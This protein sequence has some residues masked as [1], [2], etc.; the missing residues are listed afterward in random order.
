M[1][2]TLNVLGT[3]SALP[4][5]NR[6]PSAQVLDVRGRLFLI[7][8]GEGT[9]IRI[10]AAGLSY[11]KIEAIFISHIHGD[12]IFGLF[13]LLSTMA[14]LGRS[15]KLDIYAPRSFAPVLKFFLSYYGEGLN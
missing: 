4:I 10:R 15:G 14:M 3:A 7:D 5:I 11:L 1:N 2:F 8:C 12:H 9:Q 6:F 13:G